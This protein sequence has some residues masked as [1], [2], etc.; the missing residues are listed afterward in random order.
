MRSA[1]VSGRGKE[2]DALMPGRGGEEAV[3]EELLDIIGYAK[4]H[5]HD[6][7]AGQGSRGLNRRKQIGSA[8]DHDDV[9]RGR[10]SVR[11]FDVEAGLVSPAGI[12]CG[13]R[14]LG[15]ARLIDLREVR[16]VR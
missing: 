8:L 13:R 4:T 1:V 9:G 7:N 16:R 10:Q 15:P 2:R 11:P 6:G 5:R 12:L 3:G 14:L